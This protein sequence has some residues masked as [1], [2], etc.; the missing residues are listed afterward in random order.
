MSKKRRVG[1]LMGGTSG[2]REV[3]L[4]TG[5]G[6]ARALEARGHDVARVVIGGGEPIDLAIREADIGTAFLAL[7]GRGGEDD[8]DGDEDPRFRHDPAIDEPLIRRGKD[9]AGEDHS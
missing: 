4:K 5:E 6:V 7:H 2:E 9:A 1:V 8:A 3:S